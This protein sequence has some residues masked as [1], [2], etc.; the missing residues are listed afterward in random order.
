MTALRESL[1]AP[2]SAEIV[3]ELATL[4]HPS[5][6]DPIRVV[7]YP[8]HGFELVSTVEAVARTF[9]AYPFA[10]TWPARDPDQPFAGARFAISNVIAQDGSDDPL[11]LAALRGLPGWARVTFEAVQVSAPDTI[12]IRT[13]P[14]R[15]TGLSYDESTI[16]GTL[17]MPD[18]TTRRAG[19]RFTPDRYPHLR[20]G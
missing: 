5:W 6:V 4:D 20:A 10:L 15:L 3:V 17:T 16:S 9:I 7:N 14:L 1:Y 12:L 2:G 13:T 8:V 18:F 11:V 19:Y